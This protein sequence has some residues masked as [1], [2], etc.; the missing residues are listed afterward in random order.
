MSGYQEL[1]DAIGIA[2]E[3]LQQI[4]RKMRK[5][6]YKIKVQAFMLMLKQIYMG[7]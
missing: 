6:T 2:F 5:Q 1:K 4:L 3:A 7:F